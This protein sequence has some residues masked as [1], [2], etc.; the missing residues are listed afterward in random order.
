[1]LQPLV[2]GDP[3]PTYY[4][5][6]MFTYCERL[7]RLVGRVDEKG[8]ALKPDQYPALCSVYTCSP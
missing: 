8:A 1:V 6:D 5:T 3:P 4:R 7:G 2:T